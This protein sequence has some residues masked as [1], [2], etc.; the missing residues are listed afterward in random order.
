MTRDQSRQPVRDRRP[1]ATGRG[2]RWR[3]CALQ[4]RSPRDRGETPSTGG[5]G[6]RGSRVPRPHRRCAPHPPPRR[7]PGPTP[8]PGR[9]HGCGRW[10]ARSRPAPPPVPP[11]QRLSTSSFRCGRRSST[12]PRPVR[13]ARRRVPEAGGRRCT[14]AAVGSRAR[15]RRGVAAARRAVSH[16][17]R[18][19]RS[20]RSTTA[21][22]WPPWCRRR[23][24][25]PGESRST[26]GRSSSSRAM[27]N[28]AVVTA[29]KRSPGPSPR[30]RWPMASTFAKPRRVMSTPAG[31]ADPEVNTVYA[32]A[33]AGTATGSSG[34]AT[35][36]SSVITTRSPPSELANVAWSPSDTT[37][38]RASRAP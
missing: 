26:R 11:R 30:S 7:G 18:S 28:A 21:T 9:T 20:A 37:S 32:K 6:G 36:C 25:S 19:R 8:R 24:R 4:A 34:S 17:G 31:P 5:G 33:S 16:A 35:F 14:T 29:T 12:A 13:S 3:T 10:P 15:R 1:R 22:G 38:R 27:S 2:R 23:P